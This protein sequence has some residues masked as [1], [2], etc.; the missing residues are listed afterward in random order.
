MMPIR[1]LDNNKLALIG[2]L[3]ISL[4]LNGLGLWWGLPSYDGWAVDEIVPA[5]VQNGIANGFSRGWNDSYP[6]LHYYLLTLSYSPIFLF[7]QFHPLTED[8]LNTALFYMGRILS[9]LMGAGIVLL[10]Y[11]CG[12]EIYDELSALIAGGL[13]MGIA[14]FVYYAKTA[15]VDVPYVFWVICSLFFYIRILKNHRLRDYLWFAATATLAVC[16]KDQAYGFYVLAPLPIL[17]SRYAFEKRRNDAASWIATLIN[18]KN[19][20]AL[21]AGALVF[22]LTQN[23]LFNWDGFIAHFKFIAGPAQIYSNYT[24][25]VAGHASMT[26]QSVKHLLF[27][28]GW[29][30]FLLCC[31]GL[32]YA[33][34]QQKKNYLLLALLI[35][36]ISYDIFFINVILH[37]FDRYF[38]AICIIFTFFGGKFGADILRSRHIGRLVGLALLSVTGVYSVWY[39]LSVDLAMVN[40]SRYHVEAWIKEN[41]PP[42]ASIALADDR[43]FLPRDYL[44]DCQNCFYPSRMISMEKLKRLNPDYLV[45]NADLQTRMNSEF[46]GEL[47]RESSPYARILGYRW[48]SKY[49]LLDRDDIYKNGKRMIVTNLDKINPQIEIFQR[50]PLR[51]SPQN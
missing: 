42:Q 5:R 18:R 13:T 7:Q 25:T 41:L 49:L 8:D 48:R 12:R 30:S 27:S 46:Y 9:A 47:R 44:W 38:L 36:V 24:H 15:N 45:I 26:W 21:G 40:D 32:G 2:I 3:L 14:P 37:D 39:A 16:T 11:L 50:K 17:W 23:L 51:R 22:I 29:P 33:L 43:V 35:P 20:A 19:L 1:R 4:F 31:A 6:P 28:F 34:L 10:V